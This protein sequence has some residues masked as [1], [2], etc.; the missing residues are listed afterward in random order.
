MQIEL[1]HVL[2]V[3]GG[4]CTLFIAFCRYWINRLDR[5]LVSFTERL[6]RLDNEIDS[7]KNEFHKFQ[8]ELPKIYVRRD[9]FMRSLNDLTKKLDKIDERLLVFLKE[10]H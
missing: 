2:F 4:I 1:T 5:T 3:F 9:D 8:L 7:H 10:H 6:E